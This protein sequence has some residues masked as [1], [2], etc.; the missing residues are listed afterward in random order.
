M[1]A[2]NTAMNQAVGLFELAPHITK[3]TLKRMAATRGLS[4]GLVSDLPTDVTP[5]MA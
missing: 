4:A 2:Q 1:A 3:S 5:L